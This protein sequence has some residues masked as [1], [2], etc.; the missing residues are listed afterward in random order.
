M[1]AYSIA[2]AKAQ[3]SALIDKVEKGEAVTLT[4]RGVPVAKIV[5]AN[6]TQERP[7]IDIERIRRLRE[8]LPKVD[9]DTVAEIRKMRAGRYGEVEE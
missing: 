6:V 2:E 8:S 9:I 5:P 1:G 7:K 3:L 4:R